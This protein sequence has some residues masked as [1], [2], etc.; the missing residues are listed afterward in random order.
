MPRKVHVSFFVRFLLWG[1]GSNQT[2]AELGFTGFK[3]PNHGLLLPFVQS[4]PQDVGEIFFAFLFHSQVSA[5]LAPLHSRR[6]LF[7]VISPPFNGIWMVLDIRY[8]AHGR[9][10]RCLSDLMIQSQSWTGLLYFS[11]ND[12]SFSAFLF[13]FRIE[14]LWFVCMRFLISR[15]FCLFSNKSWHLSQSRQ[16]CFCLSIQQLCPLPG[17]GDREFLPQF[18]HKISLPGF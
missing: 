12:G 2:V 4:G 11:H 10:K 7:Q 5:D 14:T 3:F 9:S 6:N 1:V 18:Q 15:A 16:T 8:G 13:S 17:T